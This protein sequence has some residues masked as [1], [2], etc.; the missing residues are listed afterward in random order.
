[1]GWKWQRRFLHIW[2]RGEVL[3]ISFMKSLISFFFSFVNLFLT[4]WLLGRWWPSSF[5]NM[6]L[7]WYA[8]LT[9]YACLPGFIGG[10]LKL[11]MK[12]W[13]CTEF[14]FSS[15]WLKT[16]TSSLPS[17]SWSPSSP[18]PTTAASLTT[19]VSRSPVPPPQSLRVD[20]LP[21]LTYS[22]KWQTSKPIFCLK[23]FDLD[24]VQVL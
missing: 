12:I 4:N 15:R 7:T 17:A 3:K 2:G 23:S 11:N 19:P 1:M 21:T 16:V 10:K 14:L 13:N 9:R 18:L 5:T 6:T 24:S 22:G 20:P 8:E